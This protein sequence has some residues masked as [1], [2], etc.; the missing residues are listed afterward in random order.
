M[1]GDLIH[2]T[3]RGRRPFRR[4]RGQALVEFA[5]VSFVL[6]FLFA[7]ILTFGQLIYSAQSLQPAADVAASELARFPLPAT[8]TPATAQQGLLYDVLYNPNNT[9][10]LDPV[11]NPTGPSVRSQ[12]FDSQYLRVNMNSMPAGMQLTDWV[13][14]WPVVNQMLFPLMIIDYV[15]TT[16]TGTANE[17]FL[18]LQG[19][20]AG[21]DSSGRSMYCIALVTSRQASGAE[22]IEW[23]PV[24][25][26]AIA[27]DFPTPANNFTAYDA[28]DVSSSYR[29]LVALKINCAYQSATMSAYPPQTTWPPE[30]TGFAIP[31][32]DGSVAVVSNP[33]GFAPAMNAEAGSL[34]T[35]YSGPY[36]LGG[37]QA[38]LTTVR[39]YRRALSA[40]AVA[41]REVFQ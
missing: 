21:T 9:Y 26:A 6:Y 16:G 34:G 5:I 18:W 1:D 12:I 4:R 19:A 11:N 25:E 39:P 10:P 37:Q 2:K 22:N 28:F 40:Q 27:N 24:I 20:I 29:G 30:P 31:A 41:R 13:K 36:G 8:K 35:T 23:V 38:L 7:G 3:A 15:D 32:Q 17:Q 14:T 33:L